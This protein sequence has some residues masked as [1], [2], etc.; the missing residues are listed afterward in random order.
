MG[1]KNRV[2]AGPMHQKKPKGKSVNAKRK[3]NP[4]HQNKYANRK[5]QTKVKPMTP[6]RKEALQRIE[7]TRRKD[8]QLSKTKTF[9]WW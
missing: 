3:K 7:E 5:G 8:S 4:P 1:R 2:N 9:R 6:E